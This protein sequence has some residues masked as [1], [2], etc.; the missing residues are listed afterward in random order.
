MFIAMN[1]FRIK[2]GKENDFIEIWKTRDSQLSSVPGFESFKLLQGATEEE[3]TVF[4]SHSTWQSEKDFV[5][6]TESEAFRQAHAHAGEKTRDIYLGPPRF[7]GF[8][9]VL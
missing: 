4:I 6:W 3:E 8:H 2:P 7:E 9:K 5:N 1:R